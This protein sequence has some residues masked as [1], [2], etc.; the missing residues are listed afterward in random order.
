MNPPSCRGRCTEEARLVRGGGMRAP[1]ADGDTSARNNKTHM[2][3]GG[4]ERGGTMHANKASIPTRRGIPLQFPD[5]IQAVLPALQPVVKAH[6]ALPPAVR[7]SLQPVLYR[8]G[9]IRHRRMHP[10]QKRVEAQS[11]RGRSGV[12]L[13][14]QALLDKVLRR[15]GEAG[16]GQQNRSVALCPPKERKVGGVVTPRGYLHPKHL[17]NDDS[18]R[19]YVRLC[20]QLPSSN[21]LGC[22]VD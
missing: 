18:E 14:A 5:S 15:G 7:V 12:I 8:I 16:W 10:L 22:R 4:R 19:P 3:G 20:A 1:S 17:A 6:P 2:R 13:Q 9:N 11:L 21:D